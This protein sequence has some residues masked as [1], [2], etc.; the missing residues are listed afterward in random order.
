MIRV[1][2]TSSCDECIC[3]L[4][5]VCHVSHSVFKSPYNGVK[6]KL[7]L[8]WWDSQECWETVR[9]HCLQ[10]IE[11]MCPVF[12]V[13]FKILKKKEEKDIMLFTIPKNRQNSKDSSDKKTNAV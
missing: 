1:N 3:V 12:W 8:G 2:L 10:Q 7:K 13:F 4:T 11:E 6:H 5:S 9:V